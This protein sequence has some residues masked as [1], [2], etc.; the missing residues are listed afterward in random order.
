M[1]SSKLPKK[2]GCS[3]KIQLNQDLFLYRTLSFNKSP[4][5]PIISEYYLHTITKNVTKNDL[6]KILKDFQL[7][8]KKEENCHLVIVNNLN[9]KTLSI[10]LDDKDY[11][12]SI[13]ACFICKRSF[14]N[15]AALIIHYYFIHSEYNY[16]QTV[17][18]NYH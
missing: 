1:R 4:T 16:S 14:N 18:F 9:L 2:I 3:V 6:I 13:L 8:R 5:R 12:I 15:I 11:F 7:T 10:E 17:I